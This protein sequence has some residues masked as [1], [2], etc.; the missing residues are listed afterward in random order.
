[1]LA[2]SYLYIVMID[3]NPINSAVNE[4]ATCRY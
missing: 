3:R 4:L 2:H 1:M